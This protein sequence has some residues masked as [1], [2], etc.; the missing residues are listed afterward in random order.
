MYIIYVKSRKCLVK[1]CR[2]NGFLLIC[3][4]ELV[5][6]LFLVLTFSDYAC[7][8]ILLCYPS[9]QHTACIYQRNGDIFRQLFHFAF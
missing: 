9:P 7:E 8:P 1:C 4:V 3:H 2:T 5:K 6:F